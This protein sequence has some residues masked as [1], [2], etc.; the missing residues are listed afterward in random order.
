M[1]L[2]FCEKCGKRVTSNDVSQGQAK[3]KK[4]RGV[5]CLECSEGVMT[6]ETTA[7]T[8]D[9]ARE[10]LKQDTA[11]K[12]PTGSQT[13]VT[14][15]APAKARHAPP[16]TTPGNSFYLG[17]GVA[18]LVITLL[19]IFALGSREP[20]PQ[21]AR[22]SSPSQ[23]AQ[24]PAPVL[25][26]KHAPEPV[27][28]PPQAPPSQPPKAPALPE[29]L[30]VE[31]PAPEVQ[32]LPAAEPPPETKTPEPAP[33]PEKPV[34]QPEPLAAPV[35]PAEPA[36]PAAAGEL[37]IVLRQGLAIPDLK[38]PAYTG[39]ADV[40][41]YGWKADVDK[42][43]PKREFLKA[44]GAY[45]ALFRFQV[46]AFEG[47]PLPNDAEILEAQLV[48][49]KENH[50]AGYFALDALLEAWDPNTATYNSAA[51][52]RPW[53]LPGTPVRQRNVAAVWQQRSVSR[54]TPHLAHNFDVA[55]Y[56]RDAQKNRNNYGWRL[57]S[58]ETDERKSGA[59]G[60]PG[61][62]FISSRH[63]NAEMQPTL[64]LKVRLPGSKTAP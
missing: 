16:K 18:V 55:A 5:F 10:I 59:R 39:V 3:N 19:V 61:P 24:S 43:Q 33:E 29:T 30:K 64:K 57:E 53:K 38:L 37:S 15:A 34:P 40:N 20:P 28:A 49:H 45:P 13:P 26:P 6:L 52:G 11:A 48:L 60:A 12:A 8:D 23:T 35:T 32:A 31:S 25:Q 44:S 2:Y 41:L 50:Y 62:Q 47:G 42:V 14:R 21:T 7:L 54:P 63:E 27:A 4:L 56:L 22:S 51:Q 17:I 9:A 46:F 1:E 36:G 58:Y